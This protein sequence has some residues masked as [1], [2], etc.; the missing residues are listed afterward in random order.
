MAAALITLMIT[1]DVGRHRPHHIRDQIAIAPRP[2]RRVKM[3]R[4]QTVTEETDIDSFARFAEEFEEC[5]EVAVLMKNGTAT[6]ATIEDMVAMAA[7]SVA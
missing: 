3:V 7:Q 2:Q 1:A 4:H 5:R 6:I